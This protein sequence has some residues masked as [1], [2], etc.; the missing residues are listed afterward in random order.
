MA[1]EVISVIG[2]D[3]GDDYSTLAAWWS[4][5]KGDIV[6][7]NQIQIAELRG[8]LHDSGASAQLNMDAI[9]AGYVD[10]DHYYVIRTM[11]GAEFQGDFDDLSGVAVLTQDGGSGGGDPLF[12][13][14]AYVQHTKMMNFVVK[15]INDNQ[16]TSFSAIAGT[17]IPLTG[18][19][20]SCGVIDIANT[21]ADDT[22]EC[23]G[24]YYGRVWNCCVVDIE[25]ILTGTDDKNASAAGITIG[26]TSGNEALNNTVAFVNADNQ[27]SNGSADAAAYG[28]Y[29]GVNT[30]GYNNVACNITASANDQVTASDFAGAGI[31]DYNASE[32]STA[33]GGNSITGITPSDE[34]VDAT[35]ATFN[36]NLK[37]TSN[38]IEEGDDLSSEGFSDDMKGTSRPQGD[39]WDIGCIEYLSSTGEYSRGN[40]STLPSGV[41]TL[42]NEFTSGEYTQVET[43]DADRVDQIATKGE[44]SIFL[45]KDTR[46]Q[47]ENIRVKWNG[48]TNVAPTSQTV[49]LQIY[50]WDSGLW[51]TLDSDSTSSADTDFDL[52][53]RVTSDVENYFTTGLVVNCRV[54]QRAPS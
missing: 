21:K 38:L 17:T 30:T 43:D 18:Y 3:P 8:E 29:T 34:F 7:A 39:N 5:K 36:A 37:S 32:D 4:D 11:E 40:Y 22:C 41:A 1:T 23:R 51:E 33:T 47:Q 31:R 54:Y 25:A 26:T 46:S 44:Y 9:T 15:G 48:Q 42:E 53:G 20:N 28:I 52:I 10:A 27:S 14:N 13:V 49:Y 19:V 12:C 24:I 45:F 16:L 2:S 35:A 50:N 6:S